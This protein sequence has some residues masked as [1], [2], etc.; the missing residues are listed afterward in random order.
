M[1]QLNAMDCARG[2]Q[3]AVRG[4]AGRN[5]ARTV[6]SAAMRLE[7]TPGDALRLT[8]M[9]PCANMHS[10]PTHRS[11]GRLATMAKPSIH[12]RQLPGSLATT[13]PDSGRYLNSQAVSPA[14]H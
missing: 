1:T 8:L 11:F 9:W 4:R 12:L 5:R 10:A 7:E 14:V 6:E 2:E 13:R 3:V